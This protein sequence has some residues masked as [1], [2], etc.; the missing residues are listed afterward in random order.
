MSVSQSTKAEKF[1]ALHAGPGAFVVA[2]VFDAGSARIVSGLGFEAVATSSGGFAGT[3]GRRDGLISRDEAI[4]H[5]R[6]VVAATDLP[7]S[8]DLENGFG[9]AP[10]A[11]AETVRRAAEAGLVGCT[12][13]DATKDKAQPIYPFDAAVER[14]AAGV[15]VMN[16]LDFD[17]KLTGRCENFL[18]GNPD[19]DDT[20]R[21]LQAY[22]A[23]GAKVLMAP[24]LPDLDAVRAVCDAVSKPFN[25][26]VGIPGKS[27]TFAGLEEAG[28]R[29]IS[30][31]TSLYRAAISAMIDA[32]KEVRDEGTFGF[33]DTSIPTP[34]LA[35]FMKV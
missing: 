29:R 23:A 13:E 19:L 5:A 25:F 14:I 1:D 28:V 15:E 10:E 26:M 35:A 8:A 22:E 3:I 27:F 20:I 30:L 18:R 7:V 6:V 17:F 31:A 12:I 4:E 16:A 34:E 9:D 33:V 11:V 24:G 32:A 2:N 21:R